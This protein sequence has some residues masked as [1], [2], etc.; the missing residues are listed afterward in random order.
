MPVLDPK[1]A[2]ELGSQ[3]LALLGGSLLG[4]SSGA[5]WPQDGPK[6]AQDAQDAIALPLFCHCF[7]VAFRM[8]EI[9]SLKG[10]SKGFLKTT[11]TTLS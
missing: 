5:R 10:L 4:H 2:P 3:I 11:K 9:L 6:M 8:G 1:I 7:A